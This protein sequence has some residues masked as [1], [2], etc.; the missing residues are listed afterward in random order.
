MAN[1]TASSGKEARV[2]LSTYV[3]YVTENLYAQMLEE[4]KPKLR[5][6]AQTAVK[7]MEPAIRNYLD[8]MYNIMHIQIALK[9]ME[10]E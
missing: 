5:K 2:I 6:A 7:E 4:I 1:V 3:A 10:S 8:P 9:G